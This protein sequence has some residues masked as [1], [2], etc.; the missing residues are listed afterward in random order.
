MDSDSTAAALYNA[1]GTVAYER[2]SVLQQS[3]GPPRRRHRPAKVTAEPSKAQSTSVHAHM[4]S[5]DGPE[6]PARAGLSQGPFTS[7]Q[8]AND[9]SVQAVQAY[10]CVG[11]CSRPLS[12]FFKSGDIKST[13]TLDILFFSIQSVQVRE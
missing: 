4:V 8:A 1:Q 5:F 2:A 10:M 3:P 6:R 13:V 9:N 11:E 12:P 7:I